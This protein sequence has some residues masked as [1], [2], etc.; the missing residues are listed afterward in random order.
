MRKINKRG[1][2]ILPPVI[3]IVLNLMIFSILMLFVYKASTGAILYEEAYAKR[4]GLLL[5]SA[6]S[7]MQ[8][9]LDITPLAEVTLKNNKNLK[10]ENL[11]EHL[12]KNIQIDNESGEVLI[13]LG[14]SG[15]FIYPFFSK[16]ETE[17][18]VIGE[19]E[20]KYLLNIK[21]K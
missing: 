1:D 16:L 3:F 7:G 2:L 11:I 18:K 17:T 15:G 10:K 21:I 5:D 9:S 19:E 14:T 4:I 13:R 12:E 6:E 8:F 20:N